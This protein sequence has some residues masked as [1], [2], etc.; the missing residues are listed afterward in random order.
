MSKESSEESSD[1]LERLMEY[2]KPRAVKLANALDEQVM[3]IIAELE[4]AKRN[5]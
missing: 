5:E 3:G 1:Q 2:M 4:K